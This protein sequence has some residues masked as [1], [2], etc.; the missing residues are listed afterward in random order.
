MPG[1]ILDNILFGKPPDKKRLEL[2]IHCATLQRELR[3]LRDRGLRTLVGMRGREVSRAV[4]RK[5]VLA[6]TVYQN[7]DVNLFDDPFRDLSES[8]SRKVND[9]LLL[10]AMAGK[11]CIVASNRVELM[12]SWG[13]LLM[14]RGGEVV[15][16]GTPIEFTESEAFENQSYLQESV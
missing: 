10:G 5:I 11:C 2:A 6:R 3:K 12:G 9:R 14:L 8:D 1:T 4:A 13:R 16:E 7:A 15:Y